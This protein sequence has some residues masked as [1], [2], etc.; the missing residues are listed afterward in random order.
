ML[1]K[2]AEDKLYRRGVI[3]RDRIKFIGL[4]GRC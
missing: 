1:M 4:K 2:P 3:N